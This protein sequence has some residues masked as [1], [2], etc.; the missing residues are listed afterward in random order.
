MPV[1]RA[2]HRAGTTIEVRDLFFNVPARRKFVRSE[3]TELTHIAKLVERLV[4]SR[5]DVSF[6]LRHGTR[7]LLDAPA[8]S[9]AGAHPPRPRGGIRPG[10]SGGS[11]PRGCDARGRLPSC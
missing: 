2:A 3:A 7:V 6:R 9:G 8:G 4:L 10:V 1:R 11:G 5:F